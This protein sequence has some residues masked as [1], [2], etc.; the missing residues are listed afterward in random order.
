MKKNGN[1]SK[2]GISQV[3]LANS[4]TNIHLSSNI[5]KE[6]TSQSKLKRISYFKKTK[7]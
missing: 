5:Q 1:K 4:K 6:S 3:K 2:L 7:I